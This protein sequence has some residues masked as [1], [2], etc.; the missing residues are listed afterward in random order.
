MGS[1][2]ILFY[3]TPRLGSPLLQAFFGAK[4]GKIPGKLEWAGGI[5]G[6]VVGEPLV[7]RIRC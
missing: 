1:P 7:S 2:T 4:Y 6:G 5:E 3:I